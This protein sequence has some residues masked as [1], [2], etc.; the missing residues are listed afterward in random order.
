MKKDNEKLNCWECKKCGHETQG[1]N[2]KKPGACTVPGL[3]EHNGKNHGKNAGRCCWQ[4]MKNLGSI[5]GMEHIRLK[6]LEECLECEF[7]KKV[8]AEEGRNF[9]FFV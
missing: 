2:P 8:Q 7:F 3:Q 4:I 9:E 1:E 6:F 5:R